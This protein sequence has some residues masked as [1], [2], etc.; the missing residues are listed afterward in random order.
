MKRL[1]IIPPLLLVLASCNRSSADRVQGY[2]E[3]EYVYVSCPTSGAVTKLPVSR[4]DQVKAGDPLF[5]IDNAVE[6][7]QYNEAAHRLDQAKAN[8]ADAKKGRRPSEIQSLEAQLQQAR[9]ALELST[10]E[11]KRQELLLP[12]GATSQTEADR[13]RTTFLQDEQR[14]T[15]LQSD[16]TTAKLG[17]REDEVAAAEANMRM[18][19][20]AFEHAKWEL[21]QKQQNAPQAG[22]VFDTLYRQ[23]EWVVGGKP[24][25]VILPPANIKVR[26]FVPQDRVSRIKLGDSLSVTIDGRA[27]SITGKVNFISPK[28]EFTPPV[29]YGQES[30]GKWV[31]MIELVF[32][33]QIAQTLHPGQPVDVHLSQ[34]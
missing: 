1:A 9:D 32:D 13:A 22:V 5:T 24:V 6:Q 8:L 16:L 29:I 15:Q 30:R 20:A 4:G 23:G 28:V 26:A 27:Q 3:G 18:Q 33:P 14:V 19:E 10:R 21:D 31:F 34:P 17:Q 11:N 12:R 25:A 2:V 7:D